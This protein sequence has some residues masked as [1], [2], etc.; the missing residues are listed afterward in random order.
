[1]TSR[2]VRLP[3]RFPVGT[4]FV[5]EGRSGG[6]GQVRGLKRY[7]ELP[8]GTFFALP[9]HSMQRKSGPPALPPRSERRH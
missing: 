6:E 3:N 8:D 7:I 1:M 4:K 5:I 2:S 9:R